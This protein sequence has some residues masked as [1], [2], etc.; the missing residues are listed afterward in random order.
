LQVPGGHALE[1]EA[2]RAGAQHA[3]QHLIA[4]RPTAGAYWVYGSGS[5]GEGR[6]SPSFAK[7]IRAD[8]AG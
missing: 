3:S 6:D 4:D 8:Q 7:I 1:D 2:G 5:W